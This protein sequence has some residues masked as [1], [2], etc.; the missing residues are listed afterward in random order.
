MK[1]GLN[2]SKAF[3]KEAEPILYGTEDEFPDYDISLFNKI[4]LEE[5]NLL[6]KPFLNTETN[7]VII[8]TGTQMEMN[9][10]VIR[11]N[12]LMLS[13]H[14]WGDQVTIGNLCSNLNII[15]ILF[16]EEV[17]YKIRSIPYLN[18]NYSKEVKY[19]ML[20]FSGDHYQPIKIINGGN[21]L[22]LLT[23]D[24][25]SDQLKLKASDDSDQEGM[26]HPL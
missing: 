20:Y 21:E 17:D 9:N 7:D 5:L 25:I 11:I 12:E 19:V 13:R 22:K 16:D 4:N 23:F 26:H 18:I 8:Q 24:Q 6:L 10:L 15:P 1:E 2:E 3:T 14:W